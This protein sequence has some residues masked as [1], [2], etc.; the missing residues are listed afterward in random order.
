MAVAKAKAKA[1]SSGAAS[2]RAAAKA[3]LARAQGSM[4]RANNNLA[5]KASAGTSGKRTPRGVGKSAAG[6]TRAAKVVGGGTT[7]NTAKAGGMVRSGQ[8]VGAIGAGRNFAGVSPPSTRIGGLT[9][10]PAKGGKV[11]QAGP[12]SE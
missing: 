10:A 9:K 7:K 8:T 12:S 1:A 5:K 3:K 11:G 2:G 4:T 6:A